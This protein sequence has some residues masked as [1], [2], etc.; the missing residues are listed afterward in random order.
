MFFRSQAL[1]TSVIFCGYRGSSL[2]PSG[3]PVLDSVFWSQSSQVSP[4]FNNY[5]NKL[6]AVSKDS[7]RLLWL[8]VLRAIF[9]YQCSL[10][11]ILCYY[12]QEIYKTYPILTFFFV[13]T[14]YTRLFFKAPSPIMRPPWGW[15]PLWKSRGSK[16]WT[17]STNR[18]YWHNTTR[19]GG[20]SDT[21]IR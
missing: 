20:M 19:P 9:I 8:L 5:R 14:C 6:S 2:F 15:V 7:H 21:R 12:M 13:N 11:D 3:C 17:C 18:C 1:C 4:T 16:G 10:H